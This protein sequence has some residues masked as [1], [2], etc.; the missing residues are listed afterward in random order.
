LL[1][2]NVKS[3]SEGDAEDDGAIGLTKATKPLPSNK[4]ISADVLA[5]LLAPS[6]KL[7]DYQL[8]GVNWMA[9]LSRLKFGKDNVNGILG[10]EMGLGKTAQTIAFLAWYRAYGALAT[11]DLSTPKREKRRTVSAPP[12]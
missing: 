1:A 8:V 5:P 7:S 3:W 10:D 12:G 4:W 2:E 9:M 11:D 6:V